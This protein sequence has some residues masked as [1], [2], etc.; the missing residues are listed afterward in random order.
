MPAIILDE[1]RELFRS[2]AD[3]EQFVSLLENAGESPEVTPVWAN[4]RHLAML[5]SPAQTKAIVQDRMLQRI[6]ERP[7]L[8]DN[9]RERL[10]N[11]EI[12][13]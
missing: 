7:S 12:V 10:E 1:H 13:H 11:D 6:L 4:K 3:F 8:L 9:I 2:D 5:L